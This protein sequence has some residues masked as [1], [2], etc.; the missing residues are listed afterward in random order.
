M[1]ANEATAA[2]HG[3]TTRGVDSAP[4]RRPM[5]ARI[6]PPWRAAAAWTCF[7][8]AML[9]VTVSSLTVWMRQQV[10]DT[11]NWVQASSEL[12]EDEQVRDALSVYLVDQLYANVDVAAQIRGVLPPDLAPLSAPLAGATRDLAV[13]ATDEILARPRVQE[14]WRE[15]NREAHEL[16]IAIVEE[17]DVG[18]LRA[19]GDDLVLDLRPL[20]V[21]VRQSLGIEGTVP[22]DAGRV[23]VM[24]SDQIGTARTAVRGIQSLSVLVGLASLVLIAAAVWLASD[25]RRMLTWTGA[26]LVLVGLLLLFARRIAGDLVVDAL[27][28]GVVARPVGTDVW[29]ISTSLVRS[30]AVGLMLYGVLV[31][32]GVAL[33]GNSRP[34]V[35]ARKRMAP[36]LQRRSWT[37]AGLAVVLLLA[38]LVVPADGGRSLAA[39]V[40]LLAVIVAGIEALRRQALGERS[41]SAGEAPA[42]P[43]SGSARL[44]VGRA[45]R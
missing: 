26:G 2:G 19:E 32:A 15:S 42:Q 24:S 14:L 25:R 33:T 20:V 23:L 45:P 5:P 10:L 40:I 6:P 43:P 13:R 3:N 31:L 11:D 17:R 12:L 35:A 44:G 41:A 7:A 1:D 30:V 8:L 39:G 36:V 27:A 18:R 37:Y 4:A 28:G 16:F 9:V 29:L 38:G 21:R 22:A 34:A